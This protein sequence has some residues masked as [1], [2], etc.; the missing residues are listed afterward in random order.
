MG[1]V[2]SK[3]QPTGDVLL[4]LEEQ[5]QAAG[6]V[7]E[8]LDFT[9]RRKLACSSHRFWWAIESARADGGCI[10]STLVRLV[11]GA[12]SR[13]NEVRTE[14]LTPSW[15]WRPTGR[16]LRSKCEGWACEMLNGKLYVTGGLREGEAMWSV[17]ALDQTTGQRC[18]VNPLLQ[19]RY[20]HSCTALCGKLYVL[21]GR[22]KDTKLDSMEIFDPRSG[23]WSTGPSMP[24]R[25]SGHTCTALDGKMY[26]TGGTHPLIGRQMD[27]F[28]P[29][30]GT[31]TQ[32]PDLLHAN[33][34]HAC[35]A[36][37]GKLWM[38]GGCPGYDSPIV[39]SAVFDP[40]VDQWS[41]IHQLPAGNPMCC[42]FN[43]KLYSNQETGCSTRLDP[44]SEISVFDSQQCGWGTMPLA[45]PRWGLAA[46]MP[47]LCSEY[48]EAPSWRWGLLALADRPR[49]DEVRSHLEGW[50]VN[51]F[52][53][54]FEDKRSRT[55]GKL[56]T[57]SA[58][59]PTT[60]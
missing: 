55:G 22:I 23:Q 2:S 34:G 36:L 57:P 9:C 41:E 27:V 47:L 35:A 45:A 39:N 8:Q 7:M 10:H 37:E 48:I 33:G 43:G 28:D 31:W 30:N 1:L 26:V 32:G 40:E 60:L 12:G 38:V 49:D 59:A 42:A 51:A 46:R 14:E 4:F 24:N 6:I 15:E 16:L 52:T 54:A 18:D 3:P 13:F 58:G 56:S 11:R 29:Q 20:L 50:Y 44:E 17:H 25:R 19:G 21:G 53:N 5:R